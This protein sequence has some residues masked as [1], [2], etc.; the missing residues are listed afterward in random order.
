MGY[1]LHVNKCLTDYPYV[2]Y[3]LRRRVNRL[4]RRDHQPELPQQLPPREG[5]CVDHHRTGRQPDP[6]ERDR[7]PAGESRQLCLRLPGDQV[8]MIE[9]FSMMII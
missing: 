1:C 3:S 2:C 8:E 7:L 9:M 4:H 6:A 5:V